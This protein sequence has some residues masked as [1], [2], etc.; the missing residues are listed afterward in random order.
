MVWSRP[1]RE[2]SHTW[3]EEAWLV[4]FRYLQA[5]PLLWFQRPLPRSH[6]KYH[7]PWN[8]RLYLYRSW[9]SLFLLN[10]LCMFPRYSPPTAVKTQE[11][12]EESRGRIHTQQY[13]QIWQVSFK[14]K[15]QFQLD[16]KMWRPQGLE[17]GDSG[18]A[19]WLFGMCFPSLITAHHLQTSLQ[20]DK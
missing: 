19:A 17:A 1:Y 16:Q 9:K 10:L 20:R 11:D 3:S 7:E 13:N 14:N 15:M 18:L 5:C 4:G 2:E 8:H 12:S 6:L